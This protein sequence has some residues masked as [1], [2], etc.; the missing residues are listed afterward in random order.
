MQLS[1]TKVE[2][3][4]PITTPMQTCVRTKYTIHVRSRYIY[5][6]SANLTA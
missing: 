1:T 2:V 4:M 5:I 6:Y 3:K